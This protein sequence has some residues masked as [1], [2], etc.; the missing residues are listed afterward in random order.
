MDTL[1]EMLDRK[2]LTPQQH[3][4]ISAWVAQAVTPERIMQMPGPLWKSLE[5]A[6]VLM[7]VDADLRLP[8]AL[9]FGR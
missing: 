3:A 6:S 1:D 8:P 9:D 4:D 2:L 5:L 7:D